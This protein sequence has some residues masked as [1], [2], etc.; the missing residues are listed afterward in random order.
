M[1]PFISTTHHRRLNPDANTPIMIFSCY[2]SW[3]R[4]AFDEAKS[5]IM[6]LKSNF[7]INSLSMNRIAKV[8]N[9]LSPIVERK[10]DFIDLNLE[11]LLSQL[12]IDAPMVR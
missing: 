6:S 11:K 12:A 10:K 5:E 9:R 2:S 8:D 1:L 3:T 4:R 7:S